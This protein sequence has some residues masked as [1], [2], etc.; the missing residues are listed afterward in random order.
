MFHSIIV[1]SYD[2]FADFVSGAI[3]ADYKAHSSIVH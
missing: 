2:T 1:H 3:N